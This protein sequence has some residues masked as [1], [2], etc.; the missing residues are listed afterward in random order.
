TTQGQSHSLARN[1]KENVRPSATQ[2]SARSDFVCSLFDCNPRD[3]DDSQTRNCQGA[4]SDPSQKKVKALGSGHLR[5]EQAFLV[6]NLE[7]IRSIRL[8]SM[9]LMQQG[10]ALFCCRIH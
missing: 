1:L 4:C 10:A 6:L 3:R 8:N 9:Q 7:I 2:C 5:I